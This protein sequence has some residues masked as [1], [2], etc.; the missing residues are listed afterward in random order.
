MDARVNRRSSS[1]FGIIAFALIQVAAVMP[2]VAQ[3]GVRVKSAPT[4]MLRGLD[5]VSGFVTDIEISVGHT[6]ALGRL[7]ITLGDCRYPVNDPNGDAYAYLVI[8]DAG[9][10]Q[11]QFQGWMIASSPALNALEHPRYDVWVIR[12]KT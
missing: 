9:V 3:E 8:R 5:K 6:A 1:L 11:P 10:D 7:Q 12:C 4:A 2:T